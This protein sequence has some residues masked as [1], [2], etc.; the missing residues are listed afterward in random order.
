MGAVRDAYTLTVLERRFGDL[1][2]DGSAGGQGSLPYLG[3]TLADR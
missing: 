2:F 3:Q 1:A